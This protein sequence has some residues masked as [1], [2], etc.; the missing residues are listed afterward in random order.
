V[1]PDST[2]EEIQ[3]ALDTGGTV[4]FHRQTRQTAEY[5]EYNQI[6][7]ST[8]DVPAATMADVR[9]KGFFLGKNG[10]DVDVIGVLGPNGERP[11]INGGTIPFRV[12]AFL[13]MGLLGLPMNFRIEN[14]ELVDP[15]MADAPLFYS[16]IG[17]MVVSVL[18]A[19]STVNNCKITVTGK[20][21]DPGHANNHSVAI[22]FYLTRYEPIPPPSG[23]RIDVTNNTIVAAKVHE[24]IHVDNYWPEL[25][26]VMPPRAFVNGN[27]VQLSKLLGF[28]NWGNGIVV[29]GHLPN[30]IITGN[31]V[32]GDGRSP[33]L[34]P[35]VQTAAL[36]IRP[37][38]GLP[39]SSLG[40]ATVTGNDS[41]LFKGDYHLWLG[42]TVSHSTVA[43]NL[44]G[45]ADRAGVM[46]DA[47]GNRFVNNHFTGVYPG[48]STVTSG[49]GLF[50]FTAASGDNTLEATKL[51]DPPYGF[52]ICGQVLDD[53]G[54][55]NVIH[56]EEKCRNR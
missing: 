5:G 13:R 12:G 9:D 37:L 30:A 46:C 10:R 48:W 33:G 34:N 36:R 55:A 52:D 18:G 3:Q 6:K 14:L 41:S 40:G 42:S 16:R 17:V 35:A 53:T 25:P 39:D 29:G 22:W 19:Q 47:E 11:K 15:D 2:Y 26:G 56:G 31:T 7:S 4:Y 45:P 49:P 27:T 38:P 50:W 43:Q 21:T 8:P 54:G 24:G 32:M 1:Y 20:E 44:F 23:A 51:N 28:G